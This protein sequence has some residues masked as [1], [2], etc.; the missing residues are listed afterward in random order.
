M[1]ESRRDGGPGPSRRFALFAALGY[2]ALAAVWILASDRILELFTANLTT[3]S[4][5]QTWK[6]WAFVGLTSLLL[7]FILLR[8]PV[9]PVPDFDPDDLKTDRRIHRIV[10]AGVSV[11]ILVILAD[12]FFTLARQRQEILSDAEA[13]TRSL[14]QIIEE[15]ARGAINAVDLTLASTARTL[16]LLPERESARN[17]E[18]S[19]LLR[20]NLRNLPFVRAIWVLDAAGN[21]IHDS[22]NLPGHYNLSD[23]AYFAFHRD[24]RTTGIRIDPPLQGIQGIWFLPV[25]QRL[26][27]PDGSFAGVITAALEPRYFDQF[28]QSIP[29]G[30]E[31]ILGLALTDGTLIAR[32]PGADSLRGRKMSPPPRFVEALQ[33]AETDTFRLRSNIDSVDRIASYRRIK[34]RPLVVF[35]GLGVAESLAGWQRAALTNA[36]AALAFVTV[37]LWLGYLAMREL[38]RR[39]VLNRALRASERRI[40]NLFEQAADGIFILAADDRF[41]DGNAEGLRMLGYRRDELLRMRYADILAPH[42][43]D[44]RRA[45]RAA[46]HADGPLLEEWVH[47]RRDGTTFDAEV[48]ARPLAGNLTLAIVRDLTVRREAERESRRAYER[49]EKIF[50]AAPEAMSISDIE[51]GRLVLVNDAW[52]D[53]FACGRDEAIGRS[54]LELGLWDDLRQRDD[55]VSALREGRRVRGIEG[56]AR[57]RSGEQRDVLFSAEAIEFGNETRLLLM[58]SDVTEGKRTQRALQDRTDQLRTALEISRMGVWYWDLRT[59][60]IFTLQ[61]DGPISGLPREHYPHTG[62]ALRALI[63]PADLA[64]FEARIES[65]MAGEDFEAEFRIV[66]PDGSARWVATR[67]QC[68]RDAAGAAVVLTG[69]DMDTTER[70]RSEEHIQYLATHDSLTGLPNRYLI[71]DRVSQ[72]VARA[73][74]SGGQLALLYLDIDRFKIIN[75]GYGHPFGDAVLKAIGDRLRDIVREGDT[76]ARHSGDEFLILLADLQRSA[77]VYVVAQKILEA[78]ERAF[79]IEGREIHVTASIGVSVFPQDGDDADQLIGAADVAMYGSK[80]LGRNTYQFFTREMSEDTRRSVELE[81]LLRAA[82]DQGQLSLA[83]QAKVD[84]D[85]GQI[86]GCEALLRWDHPEL[87]AIPPSRFIPIAEDSG[88]IVPIGDWVLRTACAQNKAWQDAGL[89]RIPISVNV[90]ARQFLQQDM[91]AN[92]MRALAASGL[93]AAS[94]ELELTEGLIAQDT[95]KVIATVDQLKV[96]G[97][98]FSIDDFGTG[99]SSLSYLRRFRV[100]TLKIDQSFVR[101]MLTEPD[102][103]AIVRGVIS[104]AH[105]LKLKVIAEGV[106][107]DEQARFLRLIRC[108]EIQGYRFSRPVPAAE[109]AALLA[110]GRRFDLKQ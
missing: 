31:G 28:F 38:Q 26:E 3:L 104:L 23:R 75:D 76:V 55:I 47:Q 24:H 67:G 60:A 6:G 71:Q 81:N 107:S 78:F 20:A 101:H 11:L 96:T 32:T 27:R 14:S 5:L 108:D 70:K 65:A 49:F 37:I 95:E 17:P 74:R 77:D 88:L 72:A 36:L 84:L 56:R 52:C 50:L 21:M 91:V 35:L 57:R 34:D 86:T 41:V 19:A 105:N 46:V 22:D 66:L 83:Y 109:F 51:T 15:H 25:S 98:R 9:D 99:Y 33:Y 106:E 80:G 30:A 87:G 73:R 16:Q 54:A 2:A 100:D 45:A 58:C 7:Y 93:P 92:V 29:V 44:R 85:G 97:V 102:D 18:I 94:L 48:S 63:H 82:I 40:R 110:S 62:A 103:A 43:R 68:L 89:P 69:V 13:R 4:A 42:E 61:G 39:T 1:K 90:S 12:L 53:T 10:A 79:A 64:Q 59:D 8:R